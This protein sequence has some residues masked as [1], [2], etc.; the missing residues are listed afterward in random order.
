MS[1]DHERPV[2]VAAGN[3]T[4][5][6]ALDWAAAEAAAR[7]CPLHVVHAERLRWTVD[8]SGLVP[9]ADFS[10]CR[11]TGERVL[12]EAVDRACSVA[13]DIEVSSESVVG[14]TVPVLVAR[15]R[16]AQLLV[17]G[18]HVA[19]FPRRLRS[20]LIHSVC[21]AVVRR[22]QCP[23]ALVRPLPSSPHAVSPP[24]VVVG[25]DAHG[26]SAGP[27]GIAFQAAAQR[28][29]PVTAVHAWTRDLPA[30]HEAV[31]GPATAAEARAG[32]TL[33]QALEPWRSR[34]ADVPVET[35][36]VAAEP[37]AALI[38]ESEGAA[39][40]VLG[41]RAQGAARATLFGSVSRRVAER[42]RCP[43]VVLRTARA[44]WAEQVY[45]GRRTAVPLIDP[46]EVK[47]IRRRRTPW[48]RS[49]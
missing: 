26:G 37:A 19:P 28:G 1:G 22:A 7:R 39:L 43:V 6:Q 46:A 41:S 38:A 36:L 31:C 24:R 10:S 2:V 27:L 49:R 18:C 16:G 45:P 35:R 44:T 47:P 17:L 9:V 30:D 34:F 29:V 13:A 40:I 15:A 8:P 5:G 12:R 4:I 23:V 48:E 32:R 14:G 33:D 11:V 3:D 20:H 42:A 21:G 25:V